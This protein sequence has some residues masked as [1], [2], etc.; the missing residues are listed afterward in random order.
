MCAF[1]GIADQV[2]PASLDG[3]K[4]ALD[5]HRLT[6]GAHQA[7]R[8]GQREGGLRR[9]GVAQAQ[10][11]DGPDRARVADH[12]LGA[13]HGQGIGVQLL[14][15]ERPAS[16]AHAQARAEAARLLPVAAENGALSP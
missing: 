8:P 13:Q 10:Q 6:G 7:P 9:L 12:H 1:R 4:H 2:S 3:I 5:V 11:S 15:K 14:I 16:V